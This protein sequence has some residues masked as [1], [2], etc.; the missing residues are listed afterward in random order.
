MTIESIKKELSSLVIPF[1]EKLSFRPH[2]EKMNEEIYSTIPALNELTKS[3][4]AVSNKISQDA[5]NALF[6]Q[7]GATAPELRTLTVVVG[8]V[9][10]DQ[11]ENA[12]PDLQYMSGQQ[13]V[14]APSFGDETRK[15]ND[16][17]GV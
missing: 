14:P 9:K 8:M 6:F 4:L 5:R 11:M 3:A 7:D 12:Q 17:Y 2:D 10:R 15:P 16:T 1:G 13:P